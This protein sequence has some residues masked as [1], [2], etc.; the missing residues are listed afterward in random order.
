MATYLE[1]MK[2]AMRHARYEE[3]EGEG[4][5]GSIPGFG[6][7][8]ANGPTLEDTREELYS[9]LDGWLHVN[10][11]LGTGKAPELDGISLY[12]AP[13]PAN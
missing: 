3:V 4:W 6:G 2:V 5:Y 1:Y 12:A 10:F 9:A 11:F 7:L 13:P 8:W